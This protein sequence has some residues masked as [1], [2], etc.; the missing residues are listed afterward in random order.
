MTD[1]PASIA[2]EQRPL[3][4]LQDTWAQLWSSY[5]QGYFGQA[6]LIT[7]IAGLGKRALVKL[8]SQALLCSNPKPEGYPCG[9][10]AEC[11][12]H[13]AGYHPDLHW[14][15]PE[16]TTTSQDIKIDVIRSIT[17]REALTPHRCRYKI[18]VIAPA[19]AM[20]RA[21]MNA[22]LKTLEEPAPSTMWLLLSEQPAQ[23]SATVISRCKRLM[24]NT[25][26]TAAVLP[27]LT[28]Q[29]PARTPVELCLRLAQ[30]APLRASA[31]ADS[32]LLKQRDQ[33]FQAWSDIA[34]AQRDPLQ[35][36]TIW[37][38]LEAPILLEFL[39]G[40]VMDVLRLTCHAQVDFLHNPD[41]RQ[42]L[43][44]LVPRLP[45]VALHHYLHRVIQARPLLTTTVNKSLLLETL[46]IRFA[47][48]A[49]GLPSQYDDF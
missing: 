33:A 19:E 38:N 47:W 43:A 5:Q 8:L 18:I 45:T 44:A 7:G 20:N 29:L 4:W 17:D 12:L 3:P 37:Q 26:A 1:I 10:C 34:L 21:A 32:A 40:W 14:V 2:T 39:A 46:A 36:A 15:A 11:R 9:H 23:L 41:K 49:H 6:W 48:L 13:A 27:W 22:V 42:F 35:T 31:F 24:I 25:P 28:Q 16:T 30:G